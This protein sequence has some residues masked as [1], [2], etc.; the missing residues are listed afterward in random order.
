MAVSMPAVGSP[1]VEAGLPASLIEAHEQI[2]HLDRQLREL[3]AAHDALR[4][5]IRRELHQLVCLNWVRPADADKILTMFRIEKLPRRF[6]VGADV[7]V[8]L[9][10]CS[11]DGDYA[12][13]GARRLIFDDMRRLRDARLRAR[14][15]RAVLGPAS[16]A[17]DIAKIE[18][19]ASDGT[20]RRPQFRVK[21]ILQVAVEVTHSRVTSAWPAARPRLLADL[22]RLRLINVDTTAIRR[23]WTYDVATG[24]WY[25]PDQ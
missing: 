15:G 12:Q 7:P 5:G 24:R 6:I 16:N 22:A 19:V 11:P 18:S 2:S 3:T 4:D 20:S 9:V 17:I 10:L 13:R 23:L 14:T 25:D 8:S 1:A 21:A